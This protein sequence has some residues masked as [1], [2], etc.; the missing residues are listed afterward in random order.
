MNLPMSLTSATVVFEPAELPVVV[1]D[2]SLPPPPPPP[3]PAAISAAAAPSTASGLVRATTPIDDVLPK[4]RAGLQAR[5]S[6]TA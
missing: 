1:A 2:V 5:P 3:Q 4:K 6:H